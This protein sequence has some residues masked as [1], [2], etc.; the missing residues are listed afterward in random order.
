MGEYFNKLNTLDLRNGGQNQLSPNP[1]FDGPAKSRRFTDPVCL[2]LLLSLW[3]V[4]SWIGIWAMQ[5][6]NYDTLMH[7]S[8]YKGRLCGID[9]DSNGDPLPSQWHAVDI[10]SNGVCIDG[11]A[12][13]NVLN[14]SVKSDL[15]CKEDGDL[16]AMDG[17]L[18]NGSISADPDILITCGGCMYTMGT[19]E[20]LNYCVPEFAT[21]VINGVNEAA[22]RRGL[23]PLDSLNPIKT[24][25]YI[26]RFLRDMY[27]SRWIV[28]GA[29]I[30][31]SSV[32]GLFFLLLLCFQGCIVSTFRVSAFLVPLGFGGAGVLAWF[33]ANSYELDQTGIHSDSKIILTRYMGYLFWVITAICFSV[34]ILFRKSFAV[35]V[36]ITKAAIRPVKE[37]K[38]I[39]LFPIFQLIGYIMFMGTIAMWFLFLSTTGGNVEQSEKV[40]DFD[41][42]F[43]DQQ[44][45]KHTHYAFW[46]LALV[47]FWTSEF[48]IALGQLTLTLCFSEWYFTAEK[49]EGNSVSLWRCT[50][51]TILR[52]AGT[53]AF[54]SM[55]I[56]IVQIIR[57]PALWT[58]KIIK[59][60]SNDNKCIDCIICT[61]QCCFFVLERYM[62]FIGRAAYVQTALFGHSFCKGSRESY[63]LILRNADRISGGTSAGWISITFCKVLICLMVSLVSLFMMHNYYFIELYSML[64]ITVVIGIIA[65]F[66]GN[67]FTEVVGMSISTLIQCFLADEEMFG[68]EGSLYVPD[69]LDDFLLNLEQESDVEDDEVVYAE[70]STS[71]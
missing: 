27:T 33:A 4:A 9:K 54:G 47:F 18:E 20:I 10:L 37:V 40:F 15:V 23:E 36:L 49:D 50:L 55:A 30:G 67:M 63:Y 39:L 34:L 19:N 46:F 52:H 26:K 71:Q 6:G 61:C 5:N 35:D 60:S 65:W 44:Y 43:T 41:I 42:T 68:N 1:D 56:N 21:E 32:L 69:E 45:T 24:A 31:G 17:C 48:V 22:N 58:Q 62:K 66:V 38:M 70:K 7:P 12:K 29:G 53:A 14:P 57:A 28:I 25:P 51:V 8:D 16:F 13:D 2:I 11:C 64:P 3:G 59:Y